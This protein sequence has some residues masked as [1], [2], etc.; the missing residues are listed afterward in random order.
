MNNKTDRKNKTNLVVNY[1]ATFFTIDSLHKM[2]PDFV[3]ITLRVRVKSA[4]ESK[5][6]A[7]L[8]TLHIGKGR[9]KSIYATNPVNKQTIAE[10]TA[11]GVMLHNN[12]NSIQ[13]AGV[14]TAV[15][16]DVNKTTPP[17]TTLVTV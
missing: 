17:K 6:I 10:A 8:G 4:M 14:N 11:A 9:P 7:E 15:S 5:Q 1:P 2:N 13:V 3:L 12:F 16:I